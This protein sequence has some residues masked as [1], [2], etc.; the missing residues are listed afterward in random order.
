MFVC[1]RGGGGGAAVCVFASPVT[2]KPPRH[3]KVGT[4]Y[5]CYEDV[6]GEGVNRCLQFVLPQHLVPAMLAELHDSPTGHLGLKK[7][8]EKVKRRFYWV[9]QQHDVLKWCDS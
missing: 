5:C 9:G 1:V 7:V 6:V 3:W 8:L 2:D 4:L